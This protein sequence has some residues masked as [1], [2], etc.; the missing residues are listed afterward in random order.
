MPSPPL[1]QNKALEV[2][3]GGGVLEVALSAGFLTPYSVMS[4]W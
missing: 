1:K 4:F 3:L 2:I